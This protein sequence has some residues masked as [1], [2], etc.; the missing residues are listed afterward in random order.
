MQEIQSISGRSLTGSPSCLEAGTP[1][2][3][4]DWFLALGQ[5]VLSLL[6]GMHSESIRTALESGTLMAQ[7]LGLRQ[8]MENSIPWSAARLL[9]FLDIR[10]ERPSTHCLEFW[11][12]EATR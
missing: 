4:K 7:L 9:G 3:L 2:L 12:N 8:R 5:P 1:T 10:H 6:S 11:G